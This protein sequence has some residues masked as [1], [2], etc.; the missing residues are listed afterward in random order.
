MSDGRELTLESKY[1]VL[2]GEVV[3]T[4][5]QA[6][7]RVLFDQ[8][9]ADRR[10]GLATGAFVSG[11]P[12][13][14]LGGFD[15]TLQ[16]T[17]SLLAEH[18]VAH[19]PGVNEDIAATSVWGS[20]QDGLAP[21]KDLD[22]VIGMWYGKSPGVD[23]SGDVFRQ[24]NLHGTGRN[25]GVLVAAGDDPAA[26][27]SSLPHTSEI[28]LYD[29]GMPVLA[30]GSV[31]DVVDLGRHAYEMSRM[32]GCWVGFKMVTAVADALASVVVDPDRIAPVWPEVRDGGRPW[33][34][35][36]HPRYFVPD[37]I[38]MERE[39]HLLRHEA[40]RRY[41]AA[42]QVNTIEINPA[43]AWLCILAAGR[44]VVET[45]HALRRLGLGDAELGAAGVRLVKVGMIFP[46]DRDIIRQAASGVRE[47]LVI[48]E[49][50]SFL[51]LFVRDA[52]YG[53]SGAPVVTGKRDEADRPL[54]PVD[55][56]LNADR[57]L[58]ILAGRLRSRVQLREPERARTQLTLVAAEPVR[59]ATF[60]SGCPHNRSTV[61]TSGSPVGGGVGCHA[62]VMSMDRGAVSYT[63]MGGEGAQWIGR[64]PFTQTQHFVQN[65]GDGTFFHSAILAVRAAV[66]AEVNIT[67]KLLFNGVVAM[68]GGQQAPG[69]QD[70]P[71]VAAALALE[72]VQ[73]IIVVSDDP[74]RFPRRT[75][76]PSGTQVW[77]RDR[78]DDAERALARQP[79]VTA[80]I[81]DQPC[82]NELRRLRKRGKAAAAERKVVINEAVCEGCGDCG[83]KSSCLS[84]HPVQT[85]LGRKTQVDQT[86]CNSDYSCLDGDCPSFVT[87]RAR[88][89]PGRR[90]GRGPEVPEPDR[91]APVGAGG[92]AIVTA[93]IGGTGVM[94]ANQLLSTAAW[95][96]GLQASGLDQTGLSQKGGPV[97][98]NL[99]ISGTA[100]GASSQVGEGEADL[101]LALDMI[102]A[103]DPRLISKADPSRTRM[104]AS[105]SPTPTIDMVLGH[106]D[107][108]DARQLADG[109]ARHCVPA[110][111]S[112]LD[113]TAIS[114]QTVGDSGSANVVL[115]G[116]AYQRGLLPVSA[117]SI[118]R[119]IA[120]N[121]VRLDANIAAF[122]AGRIAMLEPADTPPPARPGALER[123][124]S[125]ADE[126]V[127][128][129]LAAGHSLSG[130]VVRRAAEL[131][132]YQDAALARRY[133]R[134]VAEVRAAELRVAGPAASALGDAVAESFFRLLAY[135]D[136]YEVA[137]LYLLPEFMTALRRAVP[138]PA[139]LRI[140]LHPPVLRALGMRHKLALPSAVAFPAFRV[141]RAMR[142]LRGSVLDPFG[143]TS[144]R[145]T[146]RR[147]ARDYESQ[148]RAALAGLTG[149]GYDVAL[150]LA[151]LPQSI[152]GYEKIK[153]ESV[154]GYT[155]ARDELLAG[156]PGSDA[157]V[158]TG[159]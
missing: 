1:R 59:R 9:R 69:Q 61:D 154:R 127:A 11:Y 72:G 122:R 22:G 65:V 53:T 157:P 135:K 124:W 3:L 95:L 51:E 119:A 143:Y 55:G 99:R 32:S 79:G 27:S 93:G 56:E 126:Q 137:R 155:S 2:S 41:A 147:L 106:D 98:S 109:L 78:L 112:M 5:V 115:L 12:G 26:K 133:L 101:M 92:Y 58:P 145:R 37:T 8:I 46:L 43:D 111:M 38:E 28:A 45:R 48:E 120:I 77:N 34:H 110:G 139:S 142:R 117:A 81:Y 96:D 31:Q 132:S 159:A 100:D 21:L 129:E 44:T 128:Q 113:C 14:P 138:E 30:P 64:A 130:A 146:E 91:I 80:L 10:A 74:Q 60:C 39:L 88:S 107:L 118:E 66:A 148:L 54:V 156:A 103:A 140:M 20:Q 52:L 90:T 86:S 29:A 125:D 18:K 7:V 68:T 141:L 94:T 33:R 87:V 25:G 104:V 40:A 4:G 116:A 24:A 36:Q 158:G 42:N 71:T 105:G 17:G 149:A 123:H 150:A 83:A 75:A 82:A 153:L 35:V 76:W 108:A 63:Q 16:R 50:R 13:S 131:V 89:R 152:R 134:L 67:F 19:V 102:V 151:R 97:S 15:L 73:R 23:R 84:V 70:V 136:E 57:L 47:V 85:E 114:Q 121:G 49:K 62:M 144:V 6:L